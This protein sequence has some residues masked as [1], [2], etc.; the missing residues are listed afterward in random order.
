M[1]D[2]SGKKGDSTTQEVSNKQET[3][4]EKINRKEQEE[5]KEYELKKKKIH[6]EIN[7]NDTA[8]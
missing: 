5:L 6:M 2:F 4:L 7:H 3:E 8:A 1:S